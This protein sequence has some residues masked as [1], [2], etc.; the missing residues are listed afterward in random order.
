ME[1]LRSAQ[2]FQTG[3]AGATCLA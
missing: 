1:V 2:D 3:R